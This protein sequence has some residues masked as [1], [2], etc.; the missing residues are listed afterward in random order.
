M[1]TTALRNKIINQFQEFIEDDSKLNILDGVFDAMTTTNTIDS[2]VSEEHYKKVEDRY[3]KK[4][5]GET[6]GKSWDEVKLELQQK[7]G[8]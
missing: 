8:F 2:L 4:I 5:K 1:E 3:Q 6:K 7:Y